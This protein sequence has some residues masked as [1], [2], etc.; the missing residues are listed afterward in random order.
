MRQLPT[1]LRSRR[2]CR[3]LRTAGAC[4][5]FTLVEVLAAMA[6]VAIVLPVAMSGLSLML[7]VSQDAR[8]RGQAATLARGKLDELAATGAWQT[9]PFSGDFG[10]ESPGLIWSATVNPW[11]D[12]TARELRVEVA[13]ETGRTS[14]SVSMSTLIDPASNSGL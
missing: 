10:P 12:G 8:Y 2:G 11:G 14:R 13:W 7:R 6:V 9:G 5:G 3:A 1:I 4:R